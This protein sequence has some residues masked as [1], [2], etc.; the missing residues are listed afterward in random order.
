MI[1]LA[2]NLKRVCV[3]GLGVVLSRAAVMGLVL[4]RRG[5]NARLFF[6][7]CGLRFLSNG[8]RATLALANYS[9]AFNGLQPGTVAALLISARQSA[10]PGWPLPFA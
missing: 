3:A 4:I 2:L 5:G 7:K 1:S 8:T 9:R 10:R 6:A